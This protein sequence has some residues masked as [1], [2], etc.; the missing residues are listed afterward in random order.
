VSDPV[1][2]MPAAEPRLLLLY[3]RSGPYGC[4]FKDLPLSLLHLAAVAVRRG[5]TVDIFDQTRL[6]V[7]I[8]GGQ[9]LGM[10]LA[11]YFQFFEFKVA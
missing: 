4:I 7:Q 10:Y 11:A 2:A 3:P 6:G 9:N 1:K 8:K 5:H